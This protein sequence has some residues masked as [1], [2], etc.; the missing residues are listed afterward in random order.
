MA[1]VT[2]ADNIICTHHVQYISS[3]ASRSLS[4][5][6]THT[7]LLCAVGSLS[8]L[9]SPSLCS[10]A[11]ESVRPLSSGS[12]NSQ[13][14]SFSSQLSCL[15]Y[16]SSYRPCSDEYFVPEPALVLWDVV[17]ARKRFWAWIRLTAANGEC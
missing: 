6:I 15:L 3:E 13:Y 1:R 16:W 17:R 14:R 9:C 10:S 2:S 7:T 5:L 11:A 8:R 12:K 4:V